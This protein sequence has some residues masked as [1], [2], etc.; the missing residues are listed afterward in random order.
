MPAKCDLS[1][2]LSP[3]KSLSVSSAEEFLS[4]IEPSIMRPRNLI[5]LEWIE[6]IGDETSGWTDV[7]E[8]EKGVVFID[9]PLTMT[10]E[11]D[12]SALNSRPAQVKAVMHRE[13]KVWAPE[14][15]V[16]IRLKSS[17]KA[18]SKCNV[19]LLAVNL[20]TLVWIE[21]SSIMFI[22]AKKRI[23]ERVQPALISCSYLCQALVAE[24]ENYLLKI[25]SQ[26]V[27]ISLIHCGETPYLYRA[28][29]ISL[30]EM[31]P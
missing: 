24:L 31:N 30:C 2:T 6:G 13:S 27:S 12:L 20:G 19:V 5:V 15:L 16:V 21:Y 25:P 8:T 9:L 17:M 18:Q 22:P 10:I 14:T 1:M 29:T 26:Y 3:A 4:E 11:H 28:K 7:F 23:T